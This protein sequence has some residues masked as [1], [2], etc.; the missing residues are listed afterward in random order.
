MIPVMISEIDAGTPIAVLSELEPLE[1][2]A[3]SKEIRTITNGLSLDNQA[4][5]I[6]VNPLLAA[7]PEYIV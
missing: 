2:A 6:A 7:I 3:S 4:T 1:S 5:L